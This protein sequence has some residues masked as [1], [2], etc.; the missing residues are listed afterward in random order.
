MSDFSLPHK[1]SDLFLLALCMETG[2]H[3]YQ[4][5]LQLKRHDEAGMT[6]LRDTAELAEQSYRGSVTTEGRASTALSLADAQDKACISSARKVLATYLGEKW[7]SKWTDTGFPH[8]ST[9]VPAKQSERLALLKSLA[10]YFADHAAWE[11]PQPE[12]NV[13]AARATALA[14]GLQSAITTFKSLQTQTLRLKK[15]RD[16]AETALRAY[17]SGLISELRESMPDDDPRWLEFGL[18]LPGAEHVPDRVEH[19]VVEPGQPG[20]AHADW[21]DAA[22]HTGYHIEILIV[23]VDEEFHR[24]L[25]RKNSDARLPGL[26][27]GKTVQVRVNAVNSAGEG[28]Y[29]DVVEIVVP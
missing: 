15:D 19:L 3:T 28:G 26:P 12:V 8:R 10:A 2:L 11:N 9:A 13:T 18:G 14:N 27:T 22:R 17:M 29:S 20:E 7:S 25:T 6:V 5:V 4:V 23:G 24:V 16:A 1:R 21:A